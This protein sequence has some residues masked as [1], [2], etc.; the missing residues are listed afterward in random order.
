M[1]GWPGLGERHS[2]ALAE[3]VHYLHTQG[4]TIDTLYVEVTNRKSPA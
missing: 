1:A 2:N 3:A 4:K